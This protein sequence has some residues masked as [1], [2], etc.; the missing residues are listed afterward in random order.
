MVSNIMVYENLLN[1]AYEQI[2]P[3]EGCDRFEVRKVEGRIEGSK[4]IISNFGQVVNCMR[5]SPEHVS[6]FLFKA[7]ATCGE[8]NG[9][10]LVL[11][12]KVN[13]SEINEKIEKYVNEYVRC[14]DCKKPDT[15]LV[16]EGGKVIMRC[17]ACGAKNEV[18]KI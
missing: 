12:R 18:H 15:E 17:M 2:K 4:T 13:S 5:R 10:R 6:K 7:L 1:T 16:S 8:V 11:A 3:V 14:K 9:E